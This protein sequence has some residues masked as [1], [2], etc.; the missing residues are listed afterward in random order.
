M[1]TPYKT[2]R[3]PD[4]KH[5]TYLDIQGRPVVRVHREE[6]PD[7]RPGDRL[8]HRPKSIEWHPRVLHHLVDLVAK[9][10][11]VYPIGFGMNRCNTQP[12]STIIWNILYPIFITIL[13]VNCSSTPLQWIHLVPIM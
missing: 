12:Y 9:C 10:F 1:H 6:R 4:T 11:H 7:P 8:E 13:R 2:S 5:Y 3:L